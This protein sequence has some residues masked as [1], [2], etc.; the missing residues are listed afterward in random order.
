MA[1]AYK[2]VH[3]SAS[4]GHI[5]LPVVMSICGYIFNQDFKQVTHLINTHSKINHE[6]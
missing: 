6:G 1:L 4:I 5:A 2:S 3:L